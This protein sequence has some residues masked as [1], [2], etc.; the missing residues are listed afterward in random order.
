MNTPEIF[1]I[2]L[3]MPL[4]HID[5]GPTMLEFANI[6][7][8]SNYEGRS[9]ISIALGKLP[10][11]PYVISETPRNIPEP[12]FFAWALTKDNWRLIYDKVG[13]CWQLYDLDKDAKEQVNLVDI[14]TAKL[15]ELKALLAEYLNEQAIKYNYSRWKS[16]KCMTKKKPKR[17]RKMA[18]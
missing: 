7:Q 14:E 2:N 16:L 10:A 6:S 5:L 3:P 12:T 1:N 8:P 9:P 11:H 17:F 4:S 18:R 15:N 13:G